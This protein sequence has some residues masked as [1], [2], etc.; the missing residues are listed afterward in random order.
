[1]INRYIM[2]KNGS[3][4][5]IPALLIVSLYTIYLLEEKG[6]III[7]LLFAILP[8]LLLFTAVFSKKHYYFYVFFIVNYLIMGISRYVS[9]KTGIVMLG[10]TLGI[11][12]IFL[13]KNIFQPYE[14]KRCLTLLTMAWAVW[15]IYCLF[16]LFNPL[17]VIEAW[18]IAIAGYALLPLLCAIIIP[19]LFTKF[20][21]FKWLLII[22]AFLTLLAAFKGYWQKNH[23]FINAKTRNYRYCR[24]KK[25]RYNPERRH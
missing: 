25:F 15:F 18:N 7:V 24:K 10:I 9:M 16:E 11:L 20:N 5:I 2:P 23:G 3:S 14:W 22:W 6:N 12:V 1:M 19:I 8:A 13:I 4:Y 21:S 17:A